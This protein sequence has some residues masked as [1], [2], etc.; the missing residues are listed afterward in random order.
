[1]PLTTSFPS[2]SFHVFAIQ[3]V[4][5]SPITL[6]GLKR[7]STL[8]L[9]LLENVASSKD[10]E[11]TK[12]DSSTL[13]H[14]LLLEAARSTL[15]SGQKMPVEYAAIKVGAVEPVAFDLLGMYLMTGSTMHIDTVQKCMFMIK[16]CKT[17][18]L[19][20]DVLCSRIM[21]SLKEMVTV[22]DIM[23]TIEGVGDI[24]TV[25]NPATE[26]TTEVRFEPR[27]T[28]FLDFAL[29]RAD[30]IFSVWEISRDTVA[31]TP[32]IAMLLLSR[33]PGAYVAKL[34]KIED[35]PED[36]E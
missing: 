8:A 9:Q 13:M 10:E 11:E 28:F 1:M 19:C 7:P 5:V 17:Y 34:P 14:D 31:K 18:G 3:S 23:S 15:I 16:M 35:P 25:E 32:L 20:R 12:I 6:P 27:D 21:A 29:D 36:D 24:V 22:N 26:G 33:I 30:E 2:L 4:D